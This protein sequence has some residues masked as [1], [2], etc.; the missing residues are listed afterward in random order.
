MQKVSIIF[1]FLILT[2]CRS[3]ESLMRLA[4]KRDPSVIREKTVEKTIVTPSETKWISFQDSLK[5]ETDKVLIDIKVKD[6]I[7]DLFYFVKPQEI[8]CETENK[9]VTIPEPKGTI[10][11]REKTARKLGT[12]R[13]QTERK[14][15]KEKGKTDRKIVA[16]QNQTER[17]SLRSGWYWFPVGVVVGWL[18]M[19]LFIYLIFRWK[20]NFLR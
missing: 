17:K 9:I 19:W 7:I 13:E 18:S 20:R 6:S 11:Q 14:K 3:A 8:P 12:E 4:I 16:E 1:L 2:G 10:R 5:I 15:I